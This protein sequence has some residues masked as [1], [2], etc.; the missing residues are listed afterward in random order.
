[1]A[2]IEEAKPEWEHA[3]LSDLAEI[4]ARLSAIEKRIPES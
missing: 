1:V 3:V 4:T 2:Q